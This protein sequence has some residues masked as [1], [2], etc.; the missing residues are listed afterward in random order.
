MLRSQFIH[1][2][3]FASGFFVGTNSQS[4]TSFLKAY[5]SSSELS[6]GFDICAT[7]DGG[8]VSCGY[9]EEDG[10]RNF[11]LLKVNAYGGI[12][13]QRSI[14]GTGFEQA[15]SVC[16]TSDSSIY[17]T[18]WRRNDETL[19][20]DLMYVKCDKDGNLIWSRILTGVSS[21]HGWHI[22]EDLDQENLLI[23]G[24]TFTS[25]IGETSNLIVRINPDGDTL[26]TKLFGGQD[27]CYGHF[28]EFSDNGYVICGHTSSFSDTVGFQNDDVQLFAID[29]NFNVL[30][31]KAYGT[32][33]REEGNALVRTSSGAYI[34]TGTTKGWSTLNET[35][36]M[37]VDA[38]GNLL[39]SRTIALGS[40][41]EGLDIV[42][43]ENDDVTVIGY[44]VEETYSILLTKLDTDG[45]L[46]ASRKINGELHEKA[47]A[48]V[49]SE[50]EI[51]IT[52]YS[53]SFGPVVS[54][55]L[56]IAK[57]TLL[58]NCLSENANPTLTDRIIGVNDGL[59]TAA[60]QIEYGGLLN[61]NYQSTL[62]AAGVCYVDSPDPSDQASIRIYPNPTQHE[63][64]IDFS[65][66][67]IS[68]ELNNLE[69]RLIEKGTIKKGEKLVVDHLP[70]GLY[71]IR[72]VDEIEKNTTLR[73]LEIF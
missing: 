55:D 22:T 10:D 32:D 50:D 15:R 43:D 69:G 8:Y 23:T 73:K 66:S 61:D 16:Q 42:I 17:A 40:E 24:Y 13:W 1:L 34:I 49:A 59:D 46:L 7:F 21:D 18:G 33:F 54:L 3:L 35:L 14:G 72:L 52:G 30:W 44:A 25:A 26:R 53:S 56:Y 47:Y 5:E 51:V 37:K 12:E 6:F 58:D 36:V 28:L 29:T 63:L 39:W 68:Y 4:Q 48:A 57:L 64:S 67:N 20:P 9:V 62:Y 27:K 65:G 60:S 38:N 45:N 2:L 19:I 71:L 11:L 31:G 41:S 70:K